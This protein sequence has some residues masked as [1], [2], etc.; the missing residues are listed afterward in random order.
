MVKKSFRSEVLI[1]IE[2]IDF[3]IKLY[4]ERIYPLS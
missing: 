1:K 3:P 2:I 4:S